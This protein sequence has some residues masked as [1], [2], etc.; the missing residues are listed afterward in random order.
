[1]GLQGPS[2][3][4][5]E[6]IMTPNPLRELL[7]R[8]KAAFEADGCRLSHEPGNKQCLYRA[9]NGAKCL[10]GHLITDEH[11]DPAMEGRGPDIFAVIRSHPDLPL[12]QIDPGDLY[13]FLAALQTG[14]DFAV[15]RDIPVDFSRAEALL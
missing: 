3:H 11:F 7:N 14:H 10:V 2:Y 13:G 9:P 15:L 12:N 5:L 1:M 8:A 4:P 6:D